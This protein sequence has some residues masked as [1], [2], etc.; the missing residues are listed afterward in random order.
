MEVAG[1]GRRIVLAYAPGGPVDPSSTCP[2]EPLSVEGAPLFADS[3]RDVVAEPWRVL[4]V[5]AGP[6]RAP[7]FARAVVI[8][9]RAADVDEPFCASASWLG[10]RRL[11]HDEQSAANNAS[12]ITS[13]TGRLRIAADQPP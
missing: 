10:D 2:D 13:A 8:V 12:A 6:P 5:V 7:S 3:A 9:E 4:D 11:A 1:C